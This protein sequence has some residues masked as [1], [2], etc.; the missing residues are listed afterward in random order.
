MNVWIKDFAVSMDVKNNGVELQVKNNQD[1]HMG[2]L[3]VTKTGLTWCK[4]RTRRENG[5][6]IAWERFIEIMDGQA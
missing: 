4:G 2:D 6:K 1:E 5:T 3:I